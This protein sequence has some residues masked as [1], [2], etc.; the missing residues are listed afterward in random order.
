[1]CFSKPKIPEQKLQAP[2]PPP[3]PAPIAPLLPEENTASTRKATGRKSL[4]IDSAGT[5]APQGAGLK[6][7]T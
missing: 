6:I 3:P 1:M 2:T 7:P 5:N 4:R